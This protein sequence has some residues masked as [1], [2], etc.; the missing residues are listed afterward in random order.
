MKKFQLIPCSEL[1]DIIILLRSVNPYREEIQLA[2]VLGVLGDL[3]VLEPSIEEQRLVED[4][5]SWPAK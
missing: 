1:G 2:F 4:I 3:G 5:F